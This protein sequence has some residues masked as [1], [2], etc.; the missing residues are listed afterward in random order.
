[1]QQ[2]LLARLMLETGMHRALKQHDFRLH[3][4]PIVSET[5]GGRLSVEAPRPVADEG[6]DGMGTARCVCS[7]G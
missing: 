1:M 2:K 7:G 6:S 5:A 4:Q 3:Y